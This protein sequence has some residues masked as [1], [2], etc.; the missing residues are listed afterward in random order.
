MKSKLATRLIQLTYFLVLGGSNILCATAQTTAGNVDGV[1][2]NVLTGWTCRVGDTADTQDDVAV[3]AG[4]ST[5]TLVGYGWAN[6]P[7]LTSADHTAIAWAC[8]GNPTT[9]PVTSPTGFHRFEIALLEGS[10][11]YTGTN[12]GLY[13]YNNKTHVQLPNGNGQRLLPTPAPPVPG[14][15]GATF[16][17]TPI[18][19]LLTAG[20][21]STIEILFVGDSHTSSYGNNFPLG[22]VDTQAWIYQLGLM[23]GTKFTNYQ[24][25]IYQRSV[26]ANISTSSSGATDWSGKSSC[27]A[28]D[29]DVG[30]VVI[31]NSGATNKLILIQD[32]IG[33]SNIEK[34]LARLSTTAPSTGIFPPSQSVTRNLPNGGGVPNVDAVIMM[35]GVNDSLERYTESLDSS[36]TCYPSGLTALGGGYGNAKL[37]VR[38]TNGQLNKQTGDP[39]AGA[40]QSFYAAYG[41]AITNTISAF[42]LLPSGKT[43]FIG[44]MT[45]LNAPGL[46][47]NDGQHSSTADTGN[48]GYGST[49]CTIGCPFPYN[50]QMKNAADDPSWTLGFK[51]YQ[52]AVWL[53]AGHAGISTHVLDLYSW[54]GLA[55]SIPTPDPYMYHEDSSQGVNQ[56]ADW[57]FHLNAAGNQGL[58]GWVYSRGFG[59]N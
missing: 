9:N 59:L 37:D 50:D 19:N 14:T 27:G 18:T 10:A 4:S 1:T 40:G 55:V 16:P 26:H 11:T 6:N 29:S 36:Q 43:P 58:A 17:F 39:V 38:G 52:D 32:G 25:I 3:Y 57:D 49:I 42:Q 46:F 33:G 34:Y 47:Y 24:V 5:G 56:G 51:S 41:I 53:V 23:L 21:Q 13:V 30:P 7:G 20:I 31:A 8:G 22:G 2:N 48:V 54:V 12:F 45:P 44:L 28:G 15:S 35:F